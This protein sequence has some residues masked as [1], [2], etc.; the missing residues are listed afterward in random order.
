[1]G[2]AKESPEPGG[3][4]IDEL[5]GLLSPLGGHPKALGI[6]LTLYD[7]SLDPDRSC[8]MRLVTLLET[9]LSRSPRPGRT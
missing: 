5:A 4:G 6:A 2:S 8:A 7:P 1:V 3:P 9:L